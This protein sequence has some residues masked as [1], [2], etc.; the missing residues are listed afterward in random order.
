MAD[1]AD[2]WR[3]PH[4]FLCRIIGI[5]DET[6]IDDLLGLLVADQIRQG[7]GVGGFVEKV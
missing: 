3:S 5:G 2:F 6:E 4:H 1:W 7:R